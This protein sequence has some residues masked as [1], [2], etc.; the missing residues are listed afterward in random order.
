MQL[1][2]LSFALLRG[3]VKSLAIFLF[4][5]EKYLLAMGCCTRNLNEMLHLHASDIDQ[6]YVVVP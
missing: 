3:K 5:E 6:R 2:L 4:L 1:K